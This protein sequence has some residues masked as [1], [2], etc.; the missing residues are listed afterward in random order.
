MDNPGYAYV[1]VGTPQGQVQASYPAD[2][3]DYKQHM[4]FSM[5]LAGAWPHLFVKTEKGSFLH[6]SL[7][8]KSPVDARVNNQPAGWQLTEQ[9]S[10]SLCKSQINRSKLDPF[11]AQMVDK[12]SADMGQPSKAAQ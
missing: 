5:S 4:S 11:M 12:A 1:A 7:D 8:E 6:F 3:G 9:D 2:P 10:E